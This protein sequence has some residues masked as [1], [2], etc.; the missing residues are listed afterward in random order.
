MTIKEIKSKMLEY[1]DYYGFKIYNYEEI[2]KATSK[3]ELNEILHAHRT[4]M[5]DMLCDA[6][7]GI[8]N[9]QIKLGLDKLI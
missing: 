6:I 7:S 5:E 8:N 2:E 4:H 1:E 3:K 9:L